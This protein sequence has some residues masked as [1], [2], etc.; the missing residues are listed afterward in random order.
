MP[1][2]RPSAKV[3]LALIV[4]GAALVW[5]LG[6]RSRAALLNAFLTLSWGVVLVSTLTP[7]VYQMLDQQIRCAFDLSLGEVP[8]ERLANLLLFVPLG[9]AT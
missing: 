3:L 9:C 8:R 2:F 6:G 5:L 4:L 1:E 7:S